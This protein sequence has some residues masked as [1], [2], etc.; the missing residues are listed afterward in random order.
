ML[1]KVVYFY[2]ASS[3]NM[4]LHLRDSKVDVIENL[5]KTSQPA[6]PVPR[7]IN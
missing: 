5:N 1:L 3:N 7:E 6:V 4:K 2:R